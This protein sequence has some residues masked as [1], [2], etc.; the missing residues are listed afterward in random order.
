[1]VRR[2]HIQGLVA[3]GQSQNQ[4]PVF[5]PFHAVF[6]FCMQEVWN[7]LV[8]LHILS[9]DFVASLSQGF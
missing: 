6:L 1:M 5:F 3:K 9:K 7:I 2:A 4:T 8:Q